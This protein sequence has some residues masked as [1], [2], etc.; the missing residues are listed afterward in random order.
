MMKETSR[1][2][3]VALLRNS[4]EKM[5]TARREHLIRF[6]S[7]LDLLEKH[8]GGARTLADCSGRMVWPKRGVYFFRE[9]GEFRTDTGD[10]PRIVRV[11]THALKAGSGTK[12]WTRLSQHTG[13]PSTGGGNHRG[14]IFRLIV[15]A[16]LIQ[17]DGFDFPTWGDGNT[18]ARDVRLGERDLES[19]VSRVIG[20][21][22]FLWL[23]IEDDAGPNSLRGIIERNSIALLSNYNKRCL[24]PPS[25][26]WLGHHS[27]RERVRKSGLWN[28]NHVEESYD[29]EFLHK[30]EQLVS[31]TAV[32]S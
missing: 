8:I 4:A 30:L 17:R 12:L 26:G 29:P 20:Q 14:S 1:A 24:D 9:P 3:I 18:A 25:S 32:G 23:S 15:G 11:G 22:P 19:E 28:Q 27:N 7:I 5:N 6:Y 31:T 21:M 10:G 2:N 16:A 13:Q